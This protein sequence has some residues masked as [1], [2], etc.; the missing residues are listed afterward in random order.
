MALSGNTTGGGDEVL[1]EIKTKTK[2]A[3]DGFRTVRKVAT[4]E[5]GKIRETVIRTNV[6][7]GESF[8]TVTERGEKL[9]E[10]LGDLAKKH[11]NVLIVA[12]AAAKAIK[13]G[14]ELALFAAKR[15]NDAQSR[16][17]M[18]SYNQMLAAVD[19]LKVSLGT[20]LMPALTAVAKVMETIADAAS[21][22]VDLATHRSRGA[23]PAEW[24]GTALDAEKWINMAGMQGMFD[25]PS[26]PSQ[27][28]SNLVGDVRSK[29]SL[30]PLVFEELRRQ[31]ATP[32]AAKALG[33]IGDAVTTEVTQA[34]YEAERDYFMRLNKRRGGGGRRAGDD[35]VGDPIYGFGGGG[36]SGPIGNYARNRA[37]REGD[38]FLAGSRAAS[39]NQATLDELGQVSERM[40]EAEG[41]VDR[42]IAKIEAATAGRDNLLFRIFG[43][44]ADLDLIAGGLTKIEQAAIV[45]APAFGALQAA[46][47]A[48][49]QTWIDGQGGYVKAIKAAVAQALAA[50]AIQSTVEAL[51]N[52]A[53]GIAYA[54]NPTTAALAA[55]HFAAAKA[56]GVTAAA[57]A[58]GARL[59]GGTAPATAGAGGGAAAGAAASGGGGGN[60]G[61]RSGGTGGER[62]IH[63]TV[64]ADDSI[65]DESVR[66]RQAIMLRTIRR[67]LGDAGAAGGAY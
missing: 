10:M 54:A 39:V 9:G 52:V 37:L 7:T 35:F 49:L 40:A 2:A 19:R 32:E 30:G 48:A 58:V 38:E 67:A 13:E 24:K 33:A 42:A 59:L 6:L 12:A 53:L 28:L 31:V 47:G 36:A 14:F 66:R 41:L 18:D 64:I 17:F 57:A 11:Q 5:F 20:A 51:K 60:S 8:K 23:T 65:F 63:V 56:H 61:Y 29:L 15:T 55:G 50:T 46:V 43:T 1:L 45:A 34:I 62:P 25:M 21:F 26:R 16:R 4:D 22:I 27:A 44:P 3:E